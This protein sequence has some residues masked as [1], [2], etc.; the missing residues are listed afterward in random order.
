[1]MID[2]NFYCIQWSEAAWSWIFPFN[3]IVDK[4][5]VT[6]FRSARTINSSTSYINIGGKIQGCLMRMFAATFYLRLRKNPR[7]IR[8][9][10]RCSHGQLMVHQTL[11]LVKTS[12]MSSWRHF[13][14][15]KV[16][17]YVI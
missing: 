15:Y 14:K 4:N 10:P 7:R 5:V 9:T 12:E 2:L 11:L 13:T 16:I 17:I 8:T 3:G 1:M 6:W